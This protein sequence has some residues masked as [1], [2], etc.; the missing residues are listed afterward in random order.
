MATKNIFELLPDSDP[1]TETNQDDKKP[2]KTDKK[3]EKNI[4]A[5]AQSQAKPK[6][7]KASGFLILWLFFLF[8]HLAPKEDKPA[9]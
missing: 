9:G 2:V 1:E 8:N 4:P 7:V 6:D 3:K 5:Q